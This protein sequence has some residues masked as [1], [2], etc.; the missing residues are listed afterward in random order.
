MLGQKLAAQ[1]D[2]KYR[3]KIEIYMTRR[4][5]RKEEK[6]PKARFMSGLSLEIR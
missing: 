4:G 1:S 6:T 3:K 5:T 2:S